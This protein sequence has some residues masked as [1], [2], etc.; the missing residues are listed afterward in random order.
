MSEIK[1]A[2]SQLQ[3]LRLWRRLTQTQLADLSGIKLSTIQKHERGVQKSAAL[4]VAGPL[5]HALQVSIEALFTA[6]VSNKLLEK[7]SAPILVMPP[8]EKPE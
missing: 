4:D 7:D 5:A 6:S 8:Q 3:R 2:L 1:Y